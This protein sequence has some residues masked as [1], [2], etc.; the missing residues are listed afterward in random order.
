MRIHWPV[1]NILLLFVIPFVVALYLLLSGQY[2]NL[3]SKQHG[4]LIN[5]PY[6]L[7]INS[8]EYLAGT[9]TTNKWT[10]IYIQPQPCAAICQQQKQILLNL[11]AAL[12]KDRTRVTILAL[13]DIS[14]GPGIKDNSFL[15]INPK[16]FYVMYYNA[17]TKLSD[18]LKD[19]RKLLKY[20]HD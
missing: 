1:F 10:L 5:Q 11:H 9:T 15:I 4:T 7:S 19:L 13:S 20:S 2:K 6:K 14:Y 18:T 8:A 3:P 17:T 12:G 16:G